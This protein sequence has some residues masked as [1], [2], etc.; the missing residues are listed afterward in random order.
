MVDTV[1]RFLMGFCTV[2]GGGGFILAALYTVLSII[3][4]LPEV[5]DWFSRP[6]VMVW[7]ASVASGFLSLVILPFTKEAKKGRR[8]V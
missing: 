6:A 5:P 8:D 4:P 1:F 2:V 3:L 7:G